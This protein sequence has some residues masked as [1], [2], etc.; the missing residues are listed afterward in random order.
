MDTFW[1]FTLVAQLG[2]F[3]MCLILSKCFQ[4]Y[5]KKAL[6]K[7]EARNAESRTDQQQQGR[8]DQQVK[9]RG[10]VSNNIFLPI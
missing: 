5:S 1:I 9:L 2:L 10:S 6:A 3:L 7:E 8:N 4:Y